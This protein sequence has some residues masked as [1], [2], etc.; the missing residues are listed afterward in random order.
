ME[1]N[2]KYFSRIISLNIIF[3][4]TLIL[5]NYIV[6]VNDCRIFFASGYLILFIL[7]FYFGQDKKG[8]GV[9]IKL[10]T[11][12][13][14]IYLISSF[15]IAPF[16]GILL[17]NNPLTSYIMIIIS[18]LFSSVMLTFLLN[19]IYGIQRISLIIL[20]TTIV[21]VLANFITFKYGQ[22]ILLYMFA[23]SDRFLYLDKS[24]LI[25]IIWNLFV[26]IPLAFGLNIKVKL[27]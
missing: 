24:Q 1:V 18:S 12:I 27:K 3:I 19:K 23:F 13:S 9:L 17:L 5:I 20:S 26:S 25:F 14:L 10:F 2:L 4:F 6:G 16:V 15:V 7:S 11:G 22:Y 21:S 8:Y